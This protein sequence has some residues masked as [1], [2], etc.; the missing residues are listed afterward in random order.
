MNKDADQRAGHSRS[1]PRGAPGRTGSA[2]RSACEGGSLPKAAFEILLR[3]VCEFTI[4]VACIAAAHLSSHFARVSATR[5]RTRR[6]ALPAPLAIALDEVRRSTRRSARAGPSCHGH[7]VVGRED[8]LRGE[9][10]DRARH[11]CRDDLAELLDDRVARE[12]STGRRLS[13]GRNLYQRISPRFMRE[14]VP[15]L[16]VPREPVFRVREL[17]RHHRCTRVA[18]GVV[19]S[20]DHDHLHNLALRSRDTGHGDDAVVDLS[21]GTM[22]WHAPSVGPTEHACKA[23]LY[24]AISRP[25]RPPA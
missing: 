6:A 17:A 21:G 1:P 11:R 7:A 14:L 12:E 15:T 25:D 4:R 20:P 18:P 5:I 9:P 3:F 13:G 10:T 8:E 2:T 23:A 24:S 22:R 19:G 16:A